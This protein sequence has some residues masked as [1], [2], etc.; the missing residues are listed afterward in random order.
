MGGGSRGSAGGRSGGAGGGGR[1]GGAG[2]VVCF[3]EV[4]V[5]LQ[6]APQAPEPES[7]NTLGGEKGVRGRMDLSG[8]DLLTA[9]SLSRLGRSVTFATMLPAGPVGDAAAMIA[10]AAGCDVSHIV[11]DN[12]T[13][14]EIGAEFGVAEAFMLYQ[15]KHS[16]FCRRVDPRDYDWTSILRHA[17][18]LLASAISASISHVAKSAWSHA[19][20]KARDARVPVVVTAG[21]VAEMFRDCNLLLQTLKP[22]MPYI[23]VLVLSE[24]AM[25]WTHT[26]SLSLSF[27]LCVF[28]SLPTRTQLALARLEGISTTTPVTTVSASAAG[29]AGAASSLYQHPTSSTYSIALAA[30]RLREDLKNHTASYIGL[31]SSRFGGGGSSSSSAN[32]SSSFAGGDDAADGGGGGGGASPRVP[33]TVEKDGRRSLE[34]GHAG[35]SDVLSQLRSLWKIPYICCHFERRMPAPPSATTTTSSSS[36]AAAATATAA[37]SRSDTAAARRRRRWRVSWSTVASAGGVCVTTAA[38]PIQFQLV[39][40]RGALSSWTSGFLD[41]ALDHPLPNPSLGAGT[42]SGGGGGG[43]GGGSGA[44]GAS[45]SG[46]G[47]GSG[48][49][50][51]GI[52]G[53]AVGGRVPP[54]HIRRH[55]LQR[56]LRRADVLSALAQQ[57][58]G[59]MCTV[60]DEVLE[61]TLLGLAPKNAFP[62]V[63]L[64]VGT[65]ANGRARAEIHR[66]AAACPLVPQLSSALLDGL[67]AAEIAVVAAGLREAGVRVVEIFQTGGRPAPPPPS[68]TPLPLS[69]G[70][71]DEEPAAKSLHKLI[72]GLRGDAEAPSLIVGVGGVRTKAYAKRVVA[73]GADFLCSPCLSEEVAGVCEHMGSVLIP[74]C[75]GPTEVAHALTMGLT[76]I[77]LFAADAHGGPDL[78]RELAMQY[79]TA[80]FIPHLARE[81]K[82]YSG[83]ANVMPYV[84]WTPQ[85]DAL[86]TFARAGD[87]EAVAELAGRHVARARAGVGRP[88]AAAAEGSS[89][90]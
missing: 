56:A 79:P 10:K 90:L 29:S 3:G 48:V 80:R 72:S 51:S 41:F 69:S 40:R 39:D 76:D 75:S 54:P 86:A 84:R 37:S 74:L 50:A 89:K 77:T 44:G 28:L 26:H 42:H 70:E 82:L 21:W 11:Y 35:Y 17:G 64:V 25:V 49:V 12:A 9:V 5:N 53:G 8:T 57:R 81:P 52:L 7:E 67:T 36:A 13:D 4:L 62:S 20:R 23:S 88:A 59:T 78:L 66:A 58:Q 47:V 6:S 14:A 46:G 68:R 38:R 22:M 27:S 18:C 32:S 55:A 1:S 45:S 31:A 71:E 85:D 34:G 87:A 65:R 61:D 16:S 30:R 60:S 2:G 19:I 33:K 83:C 15:H 63:P 73:S 24:D 43:G